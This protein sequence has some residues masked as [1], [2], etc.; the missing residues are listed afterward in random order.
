MTGNAVICLEGVTRR[1]GGIAAVDAVTLDLREGEF[2][3]L[4][5]PSGCGKTTLL[6][7]AAGFERP[8]EGA[9][10]LDGRDITALR[11]NRR[12]INLMFQSY[13]LFPHMSVRAN[14]AYGLEM[15]RL[16]RREIVRRVD[17]ILAMTELT[18]LAD[19]RPAQLSGGQQQRVA[20]ARAV[21][22]RPRVL[23]LDE[24]LGALD[25]KLREQM[26]LEL[27]RL[28]EELGITFVIVTHDQEEA[29]VMADRIA[30]MKDGRI[31]Q[32]DT[33]RTIYESPASRFAAGFIGMTNFFEGEASEDGMA[34]TGLGTLAVES[35]L[36][37]GTRCALSVRP[38]R[39]RLSKGARLEDCNAV[40][41]TVTAMAYHG[42]DIGLHVAVP[43]MER[44]V[45]VRIPASEDG[46]AGIATGETIWCNWRPEHGRLLKD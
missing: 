8:D 37:I 44:R 43:G 10:L 42:Q 7:I 5:G 11:A 45:L 26:Q 19:R 33:P 39:I 31:V 4:L 18:A 21:V 14:I 3:A 24:P 20:L 13:A 46:A 6:R 22:K 28:Q 27:K 12:P 32:V 25:K 36:P 29:L 17:A 40:E 34:I 35:P 41:G 2:F 16:A 9:V 23:L 15:E 30:L 38:E 1:F